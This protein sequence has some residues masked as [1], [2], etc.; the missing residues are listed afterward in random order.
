MGNNIRVSFLGIVLN[1]GWKFR[2]KTA[3]FAGNGRCIGLYIPTFF[4][5]NVFFY[6]FQT[7]I[8]E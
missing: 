6:T 5:M 2:T 3:C 1:S 4:G 7:H 8:I